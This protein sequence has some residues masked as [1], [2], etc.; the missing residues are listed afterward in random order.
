LHEA[1]ERNRLAGLSHEQ[2][3]LELKK[4][5]A[6]LLKE[7]SQQTGEAQ[8]KT[9][10]RAVEI[11]TTIKELQHSGKGFG[12][13]SSDS[14]TRTGNFLGHSSTAI[15]SIGERQLHALN[16]IVRNTSAKGTINGNAAGTSSPSS[17]FPP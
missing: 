11:N 3:I 13:K 8:L 1:E 2:K 7:A 17:A 15:V 12:L 9:E 4:Q 16:Q 10:T 14:L 6:E 5:E